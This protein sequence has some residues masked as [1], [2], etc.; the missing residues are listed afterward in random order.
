MSRPV[1]EVA[2]RHYIWQHV[3]DTEIIRMRAEMCVADNAGDAAFPRTPLANLRLCETR[4]PQEVCTC[5]D[6]T[7]KWEDRKR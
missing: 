3:L 5:A 1:I 2:A 7:L 4:W 6:Y